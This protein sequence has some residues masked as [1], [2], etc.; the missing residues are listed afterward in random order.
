MDV[1]IKTDLELEVAY[2]W[3]NPPPP[4]P[5]EPRRCKFEREQARLDANKRDW[6]NRL[7]WAQWTTGK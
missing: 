4:K 1:R 2:S 5:V 7:V 3:P 6:F